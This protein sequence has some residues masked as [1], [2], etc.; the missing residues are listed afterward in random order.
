MRRV[1]YFLI[2]VFTA[3][4]AFAASISSTA[5]G[6]DWNNTAT[7]SGGVI[8]GASDDVT[9]NGPVNVTTNVSANSVTIG[10]NSLTISSNKLT[11]TTRVSDTTRVLK[12][13]SGS[14][15]QI[16]GNLTVSDNNTTT[17]NRTIAG[18]L[19]VGGDVTLTNDANLLI[20]GSSTISGTNGLILQNDADFD[21]LSS[22]SLTIT[23]DILLNSSWSTLNF[24]NN[25]TVTAR[26]LLN[27]STGSNAGN[28]T[29]GN[30]N[31]SAIMTLTSLTQLDVGT[32]TNLATLNVGTLKVGVSSAGTKLTNGSATNSTA[33]INVTGNATLTY[34]YLYNYAKFN[35]AG[36]YSNEDNGFLTNYATG[37]MTINGTGTFFNKS[38]GSQQNAGTITVMQETY[39]ANNSMSNYIG[40][41]NGTFNANKGLTLIPTGS[42]FG[43]PPTPTT[44]QG[45]LSQ[46]NLNFIGCI[47]LSNNP[48]STCPAASKYFAGSGVTLPGCMTPI[49]LPIELVSFS[50]EISLPHSVLLK[51]Q[52]ASEY[53]TE[54]Y[55]VEKSRN[56]NK[57]NIIGSV[58]VNTN[59]IYEF[60]DGEPIEGVNYYRLKQYTNEGIEDSSKI[61]S[62]KFNSV[63]NGI[64][65]ISPSVVKR[66]GNLLVDLK[67][68]K[69][70]VIITIFDANGNMV[71][72]CSNNFLTK[73]FIPIDLIPGV[74]YV[75]TTTNNTFKFVVQ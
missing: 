24:T 2:L 51:W 55:N 27:P 59:M 22:G 21:V 10:V 68:S 18:T 53:K 26:N 7:W 58:P 61:I 16:N 36:N 52:A 45:C 33:T 69:S 44:G 60:T 4:I 3:S 43:T 38:F 8:P 28:V 31:T 64:S 14:T 25:G 9:I 48:C 66:G 57:F 49:T 70:D 15:L 23:N 39:I 37:V 40:G 12:T 6:G 11:V 20:S 19:T 32:F 65:K 13:S 74:Y 72:S 42:N 56:G 75:G 41:T 63:E 73:I 1:F 67:E 71:T 50:A 30:T 54:H 47:C 46:G 62:I 17:A 5:G 34:G 35:V 29:N